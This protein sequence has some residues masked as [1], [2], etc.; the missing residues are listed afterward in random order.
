MKRVT[1]VQENIA[2]GQTKNMAVAIQTSLN[3]S[4]DYFLGDDFVMFVARLHSQSLKM[5]EKVYPMEDELS[6]K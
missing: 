1:S 5:N 6:E 2:L 3:K 4:E